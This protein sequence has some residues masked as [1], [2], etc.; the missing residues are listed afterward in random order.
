MMHSSED[1]PLDATD[2]M[3]GP[4]ESCGS[5]ESHGKVVATVDVTIGPQFLELFS[6]HLYSSPN[7]AFEELVSNSWDAG[8]KTVYVSIP[9]ERSAP[10]A[11]VWILDDGISMDLDGLGALWAVAKSNKRELAQSARPQIGK[12]GIGKLAT[13]I[14]ANQL[15]YICRAA[16]G[17]IRSV[18][19]DYRRIDASVEELHIDPIP[20][21]VREL[22]LAELHDLLAD[23]PGG[24]RIEKLITSGVPRPSDN[25]FEDEFRGPD[26]PPE[27]P[28]G[29]WTLAVLTSLKKAGERM[30]VGHIR[31]MLRAALPLGST[32]T[33]VFNEEVLTSTKVDA[34]VTDEWRIGTELG[35]TALTLPSD[36]GEDVIGVRTELDKLFIE[37][38]AGPITG[39]VRLFENRIS[40]GKSDQ[41]SASNGFLVN[42]LGRVINVDDP[43]FGLSNLNHAAWAKFRAAVRVDGLDEHIAV[44]REGVLESPTLIIFREFLRAIFK[45]ARNTY[46]AAARAAWPSAGE[47]L[48]DTW[49][50]VPLEALRSVISE[51][52]S[53]TNGPPPFVDLAGIDDIDLEREKWDSESSEKA[54][55]FISEVALE[56][57]PSDERMVKYE[58]KYRR[59]V[60]NRNH[61]FAR[62]HGETHEQQILLRDAAFV[63]LL[64][65]AY[66][67]SLGIHGDIL[68]QIAEY[69]EQSFRLVALIRRRTGLQIAEMLAQATK[70]EK[71]LE[72]IIGDALEYIGFEVVRLGGTG[73][74]E[75]VATAPA[76]PAANDE[77]QSYS[78]TYDAKSTSAKRVKTANTN[79]AGLVRHREKY[80]ADHTL[81]VAPDY[82]AGAFE[83]ECSQQGITPIRAADLGR[84]LLLVATTGYVDLLLF[85]EIFNQHDPD[86]VRDWVDTFISTAK[87]SRRLSLSIILRSLKNLG[88]TGPD[89]VTISVIAHE[90]R[91]IL[92][93]DSYPSR[94]DVSYVLYGLS[95]LIPSMVRIS[96][97][98]VYIGA[99]ADKLREAIVSQLRRLP[100]ELKLE[101]ESQELSRMLND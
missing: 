49:G 18:T 22:T 79:V 67:A 35:I 2:S 4:I 42:V 84:L 93:S 100:S 32:L 31:R 45:K 34:A 47:V 44:N 95:V 85:R 77:K 11:A 98:A 12:F 72:R 59:I 97:D 86:G 25:D 71:G 50:T 56:D 74:P 30:Q 60:V 39:T 75:G 21:Q 53:S 14:L 63:D 6:E 10:R 48:A 5:V 99:A 15:T 62:E 76:S 3:S 13:Y 91:R 9:S 96:G 43:Y 80:Q 38:I 70:H 36:D 68:A 66:M 55:S 64:T 23:L 90:A 7:K 83:E 24:S 78:F 16:D 57:A 52:L 94:Q 51:G 46:D 81:V 92:Q 1:E 29:T 73:E 33:I 61:P 89:A 17:V 58:L 28:K 37:G 41:V 69:R 87:S 65:Q 40:G 8:A 82:Q 26:P 88:Y 19:M 101:L 27:T 20:L 54:G